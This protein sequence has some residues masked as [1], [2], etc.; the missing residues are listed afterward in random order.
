M[1]HGMFCPRIWVIPRIS[2]TAG[3]VYV[4]NRG[5]TTPLS[6]L[7]GLLNLINASKALLRFQRDG[8]QGPVPLN[9]RTVPRSQL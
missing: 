6:P 2:L 4:V 9:G 1:D 3:N 8:G 7:I 5:Q